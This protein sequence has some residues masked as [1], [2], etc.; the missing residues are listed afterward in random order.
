MPIY[1]A[2]FGG[3]MTTDADDWA[4]VYSSSDSCAA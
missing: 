3:N 2:L 1:Y 4:V